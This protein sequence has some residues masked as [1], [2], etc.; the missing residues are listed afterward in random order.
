M[1]STIGYAAGRTAGIV[2][3]AI[4]SVCGFVWS[5]VRLLA[6][7]F[8]AALAIITLVVLTIFFVYV[9]YNYA[10]WTEDVAKNGV[11]S[12]AAFDTINTAIELLNLG[13]DFARFF[14]E[15]WDMF[16]P[17]LWAVGEWIWQSL[18]SVWEQLTMNASLQCVAADLIYLSAQAFSA[19]LV[20]INRVAYA[21]RITLGVT[22][23]SLIQ[24]GALRGEV[25]WNNV[26]RRQPLEQEATSTNTTQPIPDEGE[27][28][29]HSYLFNDLL[30]LILVTID[31]TSIVAESLVVIL[32]PAIADLIELVAELLPPFLAL[33][34][35][36]AQTLK[37]DGIVTDLAQ[38]GQTTLQL[39]L[40]LWN[41][42]CPIVGAIASVICA[43]ANFLA[44]ILNT[45]FGKLICDAIGGTSNSNSEQAVLLPIDAMTDADDITPLPEDESTSETLTRHMITTGLL[46][47]P[48]S[49]ES[50]FATLNATG[51][52]RYAPRIG[53]QYAHAGDNATMLSIVWTLLTDGDP[54]TDYAFLNDISHRT[55]DY[56]VETLTGGSSPSPHESA[57]LHRA[58]VRYML[59]SYVDALP[60]SN[61][62]QMV[63]DG[64]MRY[65]HE[66][67]DNASVTNA[68]ETCY[69]TPA[70][71]ALW[72]SGNV[73]ALQTQFDLWWNSSSVSPRD[74]AT[75]QC[76][77]NMHPCEMERAR[78]MACHANVDVQNPQ[79][80]EGANWVDDLAAVVAQGSCDVG[81]LLLTGG[82]LTPVCFQITPSDVQ[83]TANT[84]SNI[85][86]CHQCNDNSNVQLMFGADDD[87]TAS[88]PGM[89]S[90]PGISSGNTYVCGSP[91]ASSQV[92]DDA[93]LSDVIGPLLA[94]NPQLL[95]VP[96]DPPLP[97]TRAAS[98]N[99]QGY[100]ADEY[101]QFPS[102]N[103]CPTG[104]SV[105][106]CVGCPV[107]NSDETSRAQGGVYNFFAKTG[108][109]PQRCKAILST[110]QCVRNATAGQPFV[111][112][113]TPQ[114]VVS[115]FGQC[116]LQAL[117]QLLT[118]LQN[119]ARAVYN[120][121]ALIWNVLPQLITDL[122]FFLLI[123]LVDAIETIVTL[124]DQT[125]VIV[126]IVTNTFTLTRAMGTNI[127]TYMNTS[128]NWA[129]F[130]ASSLG[131]LT[132]LSTTRID[133]SQACGGANASFGACPIDQCLAQGFPSL[134]VL[135]GPPPNPGAGETEQRVP[136]AES[137][138]RMNSLRLAQLVY[139]TMGR[140]PHRV[141]T[142]SWKPMFR[143]TSE[144]LEQMRQKFERQSFSRF[145]NSSEIQ[146]LIDRFGETFERVQVLQGSLLGR[147][148][149]DGQP[150]ALGD[151]L[152]DNSSD[153]TY[154]YE[155]D[156]RTERTLYHNFGFNE[157]DVQ[158]AAQRNG[159]CASF[160]LSQCA[161]ST[162][163]ECCRC[164]VRPDLGI[165]QCRA[166]ID[167]PTC[168]CQ[169]GV[170]A[171]ACCYG[172]PG[173]LPQ[174]PASVRVPPITTVAWIANINEQTCAGF[175]NGFK[176]ILFVVRLFTSDLVTQFINSSS[177]DTVRTFWRNVLGWLTFPNNQLPAYAFACF[178]FNLGGLFILG[179][180]LVGA[181]IVY[182]AFGPWLEQ[183]YQL[184][185]DLHEAKKLHDEEQEQAQNN[186]QQMAQQ[187][188]F[189]PPTGG[190]AKNV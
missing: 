148:S 181:L 133:P 38:V 9:Q 56:L 47:Q 93:D 60:G 7:L 94:S 155:L 124:L 21:A 43:I 143:R 151:N 80:D 112:G 3:L 108:A 74:R 153:L 134:C 88:P 136:D 5:V 138:S 52:R 119:F 156:G 40:A 179:D 142:K 183:L 122:L 101:G 121:V 11:L 92:D 36:A 159:S 20:G 75:A 10:T 6:I 176:E 78:I 99:A 68:L 44:Q 16:L 59:D 144:Q 96:T 71:V 103:T 166:S 58:H 17:E 154:D 185:F 172:L 73:A 107:A 127:R 173:C 39:G 164:L 120:L 27:C 128:Q 49:R 37:S 22:S 26:R 106:N 130:K 31:L 171:Q 158:S 110:C 33:V 105:Q 178:F 25:D 140:V 61:K 32:I 186:Q 19:T 87:D 8:A 28:P 174:I 161:A 117:E 14:I 51:V 160:D 141:P 125:S 170:T 42:L 180:I 175:D 79:F 66:S 165:T 45:E 129:A 48:A 2:G 15:V 135:P 184:S 190:K 132:Q 63:L 167:N 90:G 72:T 169:P 177:R 147:A 114:S 146:T 30:R 65:R 53:R 70:T 137:V 157:S 46:H 89:L 168:C 118:Q 1:L 64:C 98:R 111:N 91:N 23:A 34:Q 77:C 150:A 100:F 81:T 149:A 95:P 29:S 35:S 188:A 162:E 67:V 182:V 116:E 24:E 145:W 187:F 113:T 123:A 62:E 102:G 13:I 4:L 131:N 18:E 104:A 115:A 163:P 50:D 76:L 83:N 126:N 84:L 139:D 86:H 97:Q 85:Y 41:V 152:R 189:L 12:V 55:N 69:A 109:V 82:A 57:R 54:T